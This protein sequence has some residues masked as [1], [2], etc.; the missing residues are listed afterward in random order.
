MF[1]HHRPHDVAVAGDHGMRGATF[2]RFVRIQGGVD[3][4]EDHRRAARPHRSA[5]LITTQ[6]IASVDPDSDDVT[7]L[8]RFEIER[9]EC[10]IDDAWRP[11]GGWRGRSQYEQPARRDDADTE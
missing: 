8:D 2:L 3:A 6:R 9:L 4:A 10:F 7:G 1:D 5:N 11:V